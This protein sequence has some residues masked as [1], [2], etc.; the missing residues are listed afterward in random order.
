MTK[1]DGEEAV[2][3]SVVVLSLDITSY[4]YLFLEML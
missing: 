1:N 3:V 2:S 4:G